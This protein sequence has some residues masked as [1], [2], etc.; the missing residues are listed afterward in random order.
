M[1]RRGLRPRVLT[2]ADGF[3]RAIA[4]DRRLG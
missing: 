3:V 1:D 2:C 4:G